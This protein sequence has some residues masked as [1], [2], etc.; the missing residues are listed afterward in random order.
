MKFVGLTF[1]SLLLFFSC[2][3]FKKKTQTISNVVDSQSSIYFSTKIFDFGIVKDA[4]IMDTLQAVFTFTNVSKDSVYINNVEGSCDCMKVE[5]SKNP[6]SQNCKGQIKVNYAVVGKGIFK[7]IVIV[8]T[9]NPN[10]ITLLYIQG[11]IK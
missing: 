7:K 8:E 4:E 9:N 3:N 1:L 10:D 2:T 6:V 5:W 11:T